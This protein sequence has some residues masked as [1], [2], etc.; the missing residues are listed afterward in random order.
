MNAEHNALNETRVNIS[1]CTCQAKILFK[2][3]YEME[4]NQEAAVL[5]EI[6]IKICKELTEN[7]IKL[8]TLLEK[9]NNDT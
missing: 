7:C 1:S 4:I 9:I 6:G 3:I 2:Q 5:S 8:E